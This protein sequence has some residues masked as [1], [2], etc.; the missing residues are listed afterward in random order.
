MQDPS[1]KAIA[2]SIRSLL[3]ATGLPADTPDLAQTPERVA[4]LWQREFLSG[5]AADPRIILGDPV[6]GEPDSDAVFV[7]DLAFHSMCP[8]HLL[9]YQGRAH[10]VYQPAGKL[11]GFG[12][13]ADLVACFTRRLTLQERAT[14]QIAD[15]IV[16]HLGARGAGCVLEAHQMCLGIPNDQH[17]ANEVVSSAFVGELCERQDLRQRLLVRPRGG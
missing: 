14:R 9:P 15:A 5:Y 13:L 16:E 11:V 3:Q 8:H 7:F 10:L 12:R 1:A 17:A 6:L 4:T 2:A